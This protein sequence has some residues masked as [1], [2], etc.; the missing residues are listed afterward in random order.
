MTGIRLGILQRIL[1]HIQDVYKRQP[2]TSLLGYLE[3]IRYREGSVEM[4]REYLDR[5]LLKVEQIRSLSNKM[6]EYFLVF[7]KEES[8]NLEVQPLSN[9]LNYIRENIEFMQQDDMNITYTPVSYTHLVPDDQD[10][11]LYYDQQ[12]CSHNHKHGIVL[13]LDTETKHF[14]TGCIFCFGYFFMCRSH[15]VSYA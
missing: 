5:S 7:E 15:A 12:H 11:Y 6:F 8:L 13:L 9:L 4:K 2:L 1:W 10:V 14:S 3:L